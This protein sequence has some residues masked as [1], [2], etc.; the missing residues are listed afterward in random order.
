[1]LI[2]RRGGP[3]PVVFVLTAALLSAAAAMPAAAQSGEVYTVRGIPADATAE[4]VTQARSQAIDQGQA[5]A[6]DRLMQRLVMSQD[7]QSV[8]EIGASEVSSMVT[9]FSVA[10]ERTSDV[11]YLADMT[12]RFQP[13]AV[14]SFLQRAGVNY[15]ETQ[16]RPIVV[17]PLY[18]DAEGW[19]LW[20]S[21]NPWHEVWLNGPYSDDLVPFEAPLGDIDDVSAIDAEA[22]R[23]ADTGALQT[24]AERYGAQEV[25][26]AE[27]QVSGEPATVQIQAQRLLGG[28]GRTVSDQLTQGEDED[29]GEALRR[30]ADRVAA[31]YQEDWKAQNVLRFGSESQLVA[32]VP[33]RSLGEWMEIRHRLQS[34]PQIRNIVIV[35][36]TRGEARVNLTYLGAQEG[37]DQVLGQRDLTLR[38]EPQGEW[39]I[40]FA[41]G[42]APPLDGLQP[43]SEPASPDSTGTTSGSGAPAQGEGTVVE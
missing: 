33:I 16:A 25:L 41:E 13:D 4:T 22:A 35:Y 42:A 29:L 18:R 43:Q 6:F 7:R 24:I 20:D 37:L 11:R 28:S 10:N 12:V 8:P 26:L 38:P 17:V 21:P 9:D 19:R 2:R 1:M 32:D 27:A 40:G 14:R 39:S 34:L 5:M 30:A 36:L 23:N 15:A 3:S 31:A